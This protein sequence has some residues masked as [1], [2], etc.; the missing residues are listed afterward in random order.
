MDRSCS[1]CIYGS[2]IRTPPYWEF[3]EEYDIE[4]NYPNEGNF[5]EDVNRIN[6]NWEG[7]DDLKEYAQ[8]CNVYTLH[9]LIDLNYEHVKEDD[10]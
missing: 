4:C 1:N 5:N 3:P 6:E 7:D 9:P 10:R 8:E 2:L